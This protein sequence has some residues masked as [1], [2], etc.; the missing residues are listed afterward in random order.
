MGV[1]RSVEKA[2]YER[3][4]ADQ[5]EAARTERAPD[6]AALLEGGD[7]WVVSPA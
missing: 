7:T 6:L 5:L 2:T 4:M 1:F 3:A